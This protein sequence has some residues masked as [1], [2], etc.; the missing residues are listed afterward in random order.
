MKKHEKPVPGP[1][2]GPPLIVLSHPITAIPER[3]LEQTHSASPEELDAV[4]AALEIVACRRITVRYQVKA[5]GAGCYR[6]AGLLEA[7]VIQACVI[8]TDPIEQAIRGDFEAVFHRP[9]D[10]KH[11]RLD[12]DENSLTAIDTETIENGII[13]IGRLIFEE[14][15]SRLDPYPRSPGSSLDWHDPLEDTLVKDNPFA[16]LAGLKGTLKDGT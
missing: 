12:E 7:D 16:K 4:R 10:R 8:T 5:A 13:H 9:E 3:G 14:I 1:D 2:F 6:V 11:N 15:A